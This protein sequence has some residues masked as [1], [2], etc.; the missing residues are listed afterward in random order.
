VSSIVAGLNGQAF[1]IWG[2]HVL[3]SDMIGNLLGLAALA[4]G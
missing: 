2:Q 1:S 4:S 3:W